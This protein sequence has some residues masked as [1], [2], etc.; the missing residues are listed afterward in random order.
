MGPKR[1]LKGKQDLGSPP[2]FTVAATHYAIVESSSSTLT[3]F[4]DLHSLPI[5]YRIDFKI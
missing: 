2:S 5:K 4:S 3:L 1:H